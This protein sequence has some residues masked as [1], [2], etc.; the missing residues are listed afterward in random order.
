MLKV[1]GAV[2]ILFSGTMFGFYQAALLSRRPRQ[3]RQFIQALQRLE[4]EIV[5]GLTP[6]TIAFRKLAD[7]LPHP[8]AGLFR[9]AGEALAASTDR[10]A[11]D[12]WR[13]AAEEQWKYTA[14]K[15]GEKQI[16]LQ[17][18]HT[19]G[20]SDRED[21]VKHLRLAV[22]QL[23]AEEGAALEEQKRYESMWKSL[24]VLMGALVV[25]LMY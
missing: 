25:I 8:A 13:Q 22:S 2:L 17:L 1:I 14:L 16:L 15:S 21:Q 12:I 9:R 4:T 3:I 11:G 5:Y 10:S 20:R 6:L 18:G 23:Q 24:G 19:L 7:Q